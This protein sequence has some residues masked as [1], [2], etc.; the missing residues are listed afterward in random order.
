V[1]KQLA[2]LY[3]QTVANVEK[4]HDEAKHPEAKEALTEAKVALECAYV[5]EKGSN[6]KETET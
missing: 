5:A 4:L 6:Q 3:S 2:S 1:K